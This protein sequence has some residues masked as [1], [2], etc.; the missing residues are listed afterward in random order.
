MEDAGARQAA[1]KNVVPLR[2]SDIAY[3]RLREMVLDLRL[4]PGSIVNEQALAD[5]LGIGRMP[6]R[7]AL[8][9]LVTDRFVVSLP[10]R[11][12][13]VTALTLESVVDLFDAREAVECG[14]VHVVT[15]KATDEQIDVLRKMVHAAELA[16]GESD[17]ERF[18][19]DDHEIHVYLAH[20]VDNPFLQD[21][22]DRL[23]LHNIRFWRSF[24]ASHPAHPG[25][26]IS[27]AELI[28]AIEARDPEAAERAMRAHIALSRQLLQA[29]F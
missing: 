17:S 29:I 4:E 23:L 27:H 18:L 1:P 8:G 16:R 20:M 11:G 24:W 7:E 15:R 5:L 25:T 6:V 10:R 28:E 12:T 14:I 2:A 19:L 3:E 21:T 22:A 9:R 13:V 26:M